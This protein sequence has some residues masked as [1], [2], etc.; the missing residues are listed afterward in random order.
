MRYLVTGIGSFG[1]EMIGKLLAKDDTEKIIAISRNEANQVNL[2]RYYEAKGETR[3]KLVLCDIRNKELFNNIVEEN[4]ID[5]CIHSAAMKSIDV[6]EKNVK[7]CIDIN[8]FGTMNVIDACIKNNVKKVVF[9]STD[10]ENSPETLYGCTKMLGKCYAEFI[11][12]KNTEITTT[13]YGNILGSSQSI[14]PK[15]KQ[16]AKEGRALTVVNRDITRFFM[17]IQEACDLVEFAIEKGEHRDIIVCN[18]KSAT[19]G[20][21]ADCISDNQVIT[22]TRC[23]EKTSESLLTVAERNKAIVKDGYFVVNDKNPSIG[24]YE[25][26]F[27][28][29]NADRWD[30]K[31][32]KSIIEEL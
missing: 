21:I 2:R 25:E 14:I 7:E 12:A 1:R 9:L 3:L 22:G 20:D 11:N 6:A 27:T 16:M 30:I 8:V 29:D 26:S 32:L 4:N 19:V 15:F 13:R 23:V 17:T 18:N 28:S 10:K 31:E 24:N 5:V